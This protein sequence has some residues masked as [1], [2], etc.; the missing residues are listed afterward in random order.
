LLALAVAKQQLRDVQRENQ[1]LKARNERLARALADASIR[2]TEAH[3]LAHH[4]ELTGLPNRL[5]LMER[6]QLAIAT[7]A[8][9]Q[10]KLALLFMDLDGFKTVN[11]RFGH[12]IGDQLLSAAATRIST[13]I[14]TNDVACRYGGDEFVVLLSDVHDPSIAVGIAAKIRAH[15]NERY[16]INGQELQ[17]TASI[18]LALYPAD[19]DCSEALLSCADASMY[20]SKS[21]RAITSPAE[22]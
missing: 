6:L 16:S 19:G 15:I 10:R 17:I 1:N 8:Q 3:R 22:T 20:R 13:C 18:G 7:A 21:V 12:A 4:D 5:A 11:D 9:Q 2:G 14:R